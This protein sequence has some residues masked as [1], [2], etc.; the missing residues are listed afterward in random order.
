[1]W[2]WLLYNSGKK[3]SLYSFKSL[4]LSNWCRF[5][6]IRQQ[7]RPSIPSSRLLCHWLAACSQI[8]LKWIQPLAPCQSWSEKSKTFLNQIRIVTLLIRVN[9]E[10]LTNILVLCSFG[11]PIVKQADNTNTWTDRQVYKQTN[12]RTDLYTWQTNII[13]QTIQRGKN[14]YASL[15][16]MWPPTFVIVQKECVV[17]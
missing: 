17:F 6:E 3:S 8:P 15:K 9:T 16:E 14:N 7:D 10:Y 13:R 11:R 1:M 12:R 2:L 4:P 5:L